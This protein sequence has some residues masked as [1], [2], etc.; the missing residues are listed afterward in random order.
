MEVLRVKPFD[1]FGSITEIIQV[2]GN[3]DNYIQAIKELEVELYKSAMIMINE[4]V[5][6][7]LID[8]ARKENV[9]ASVTGIKR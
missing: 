7:I 6:A 2:F 5:R 4:N 9:L 8:L 3:K 1:V